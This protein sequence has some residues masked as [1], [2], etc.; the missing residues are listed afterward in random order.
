MR[1]R[2]IAIV[3]LAVAACGAA[4]LT[5]LRLRAHRRETP[6]NIVLVV[7]DTLRA[8]VLGS[9]G[10]S[11]GVSPYLDRVATEAVRFDQ[12]VAA[13]PWTVPSLSSLVTSRYPSE[14][15]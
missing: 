1:K 8:D 11:A 15:G 5:T 13:A 4:A 6:P 12:V 10:S 14:H 7:V 2:T 9:Y 3:V